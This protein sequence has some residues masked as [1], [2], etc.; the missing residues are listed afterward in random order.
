MRH[1]DIT[2]V[3]PRGA[4]EETSG[5]DNL[6]YYGVDASEAMAKTDLEQILD[7]YDMIIDT[8]AEWKVD[9]HLIAGI[10][11]RESRAGNALVN[12]WGDHGNAFGLMQVD[13]R[14]HNLQAE[15]NS[16]EHLDQ[17]I[18]IL[19]GFMDEIK[20][21]FPEWSGGKQLRGALA[22]YNKGPDNVRKAVDEGRDVDYYTTGQDYSSDVMARA[23]W[24]MKH[25]DAIESDGPPPLVMKSVAFAKKTGGNVGAPIGAA[26][27]AAVG[28]PG[29]AAVG[30]VVGGAV[31]NEVAKKAG[32]K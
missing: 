25:C 24:Y 28:G 21:M 18:E 23:Q 19:V 8:T 17:G 22:A 14:H 5:Q 2:S 26:V 1:A 29:G 12:G 31:A 9:P 15:W 13:K 32:K 3:N 27:G 20:K 7:H 10:I 16:K 4:S 30:A 6:D 11:S